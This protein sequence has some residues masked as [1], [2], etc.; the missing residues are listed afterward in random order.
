ML[1]Q[2]ESNGLCFRMFVS[3]RMGADPEPG[4][5]GDAAPVIMISLQVVHLNKSS[6]I[7]GQWRHLFFVFVSFSLCA[8]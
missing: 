3:L 8:P 4:L 5:L 2:S 6:E 1:F 7:N